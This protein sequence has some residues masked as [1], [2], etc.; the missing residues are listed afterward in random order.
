M[1]ARAVAPALIEDIDVCSPL[2]QQPGA[3]HVT[4]GQGVVEGRE[5][6]VVRGTVDVSPGLWKCWLTRLT[7][8]LTHLAEEES[9]PVFRSLQQREGQCSRRNQPKKEL[10]KI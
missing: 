2:H 9:S 1:E 3:L 7:E 10:G 8:R 4:L 6:G 5:G